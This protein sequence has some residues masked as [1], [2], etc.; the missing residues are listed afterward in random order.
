MSQGLN[1]E[2]LGGAG[3]LG[4]LDVGE[5]FDVGSRP[6]LPLNLWTRKHRWIGTGARKGRWDPI[7]A[8][9]SEEPMAA[10][11]DRRVSSI[12][13]AAP[14]QLMKSEFAVNCTVYAAAHG[15]DVLFY[16]PDIT[17]LKKFM[18]DRVRPALVW[19]KD[20]V[21]RGDATDLL[22]RR[23]TMVELRVSGGGTILGL[24]P[25]MRSGKAAHTA[26][27]VVLDE[28]DLMNATD[29]SQ[30][31]KARTT[32]YGRDSC[33]V[34]VS[35]PTEDL[36]GSIW[37]K[38]TEGSQGEW[39]G[40]CPSCSEVCGL[41]W[42]QVQFQKD[43]GG[44]WLPETAAM[45]CSE[46]GTVWTEGQRLK[47]IR[48]GSYI[49]RYPDKQDRSYWV[50]G[51]AHI[52]RSIRNIAEVGASAWRG[53]QEDNDWGTYKRFVNEWRGEPWD[54]SEIGLSARR[55]Q[56]SAYDLGARGTKSLGLLD[57]RIQLVTMGADVQL[58]SIHAE[59]MGWGVDETDRLL[60]FGLRYF[61]VRGEEGE[62]VESSG[63]WETLDQELRA[64]VWR[65]PAGEN[66]VGIQRGLI[67]ARYKTPVVR[68][69]L[70][71][72]YQEELRR[73]KRRATP[74]G[75]TLLPSMGKAFGGRDVG[76][77]VDFRPGVVS[78]KS[79]HAG[80]FI[81]EAVW[82]DT[83]ILK[84]DL[85]DSFKADR[86]LPVGSETANV[87]PTNRIETGYTDGYFD[88]LSAEH[89]TTRRL[90]TGRMVT[91][92]TFKK[93]SGRRNEAF[94]CR[95]YGYAAAIVQAGGGNL[96]Q[97]LT[98]LRDRGLP[99]APEGEDNVIP[100]PPKDDEE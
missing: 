68:T 20:V 86:S 73:A 41:G 76:K 9:F 84:D 44:Y 51:P 15:Q 11:S 72:K 19:L 43:G 82:L 25:Q 30:V 81:P 42:A 18:V 31:A 75:A 98:T 92:W 10:F 36:P 87:W 38:W 54:Q 28:L 77:R 83:S 8:P 97:Y 91:E 90:P 78:K 94:D 60:C 67:D 58:E 22:K 99:D 29:M 88:E 69:W 7:N 59:V 55:M 62:T 2:E 71:T 4:D 48:D 14:A 33:V 16:E 1:L 35:V 93:G 52:W 96:A 79:R 17:L 27:I 63:L 3:V 13:I 53:A 34:S 89:K 57:E 26:P 23:D 56:E 39:K 6:P 74:Y 37:R 32:V 40:K 61:V 21:V 49:H 45:N 66:T 24:T 5:S 64:S 47:A 80:R 50:P 95:I 70:Q 100:F 85:Y 65:H 46:C 12:T